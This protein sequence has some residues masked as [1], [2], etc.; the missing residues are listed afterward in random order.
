MIS[1]ILSLCLMLF[2]IAGP[3]VA[4]IWYESGRN[5]DVDA[6]I[7]ARAPERGN[8]LVNPHEPGHPRRLKVTAGKKV[9]IRVRNVDAVTHGFTIPDLGVDAGDIKAGNQVVLEFTPEKPG[10][11]VYYCTAWCSEFHLQ[12]RGVLEVVAP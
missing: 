3:V 10:E 2:C 1:K 8:F 5:S 9:R 4:T 11:Y 6:E 12:M 7:L